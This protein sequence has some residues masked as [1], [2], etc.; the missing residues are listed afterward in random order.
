MSITPSHTIRRLMLVIRPRYG[1]GRRVFLAETAVVRGER[2][3]FM[4]STEWSR[5]MELSTELACGRMG[6]DTIGYSAAL[7]AWDKAQV[8][9]RVA[10]LSVE[11]VDGCLEW[12]NIIC[13]AAN[14]AC[15]KASK[16]SWA[17]GLLAKMADDYV[18]RYTIMYHAAV[19]ACGTG[20]SGV[21]PCW[22][23]QQ[24]R[25]RGL[26]RRLP[27]RGFLQ[28]LRQRRQWCCAADSACGKGGSG[29]RG[30][31]SSGSGS[32]AVQRDTVIF[33]AAVSAYG[34]GCKEL[35]ALL[36]GAAWRRA[37]HNGPSRAMQQSALVQSCCLGLAGAL[38]WRRDG[39]RPMP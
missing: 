4:Y 32:G 38:E 36:S 16:W 28:Q 33:N 27:R 34:M 2:C 9:S 5:V 22:A 39:A 17:V 7:S 6:Q 15:E 24:Q 29:D 11:M 1:S 37:V 18:E 30:S 19:S 8:W 3:T 10:E 20:G 13:N 31:C 12:D 35:Q 26:Q 21:A 14:G 25:R 23:Q